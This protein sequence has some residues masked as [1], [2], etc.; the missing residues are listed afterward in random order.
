MCLKF[1]GG[2]QLRCKEFERMKEA[3][4]PTWK[5]KEK[6]KKKYKGSADKRWEK[7][8]VGTTSSFFQLSASFKRQ[9]LSSVLCTDRRQA[10]SG[11]SWP[12]RQCSG[13]TACQGWG[14]GVCVGAYFC[15][16][17]GCAMHPASPNKR[18]RNPN[19]NAS[20]CVCQLWYC[21]LRSERRRPGS[22]LHPHKPTRGVCGALLSTDKTQHLFC[23]W[24]FHRKGSG[25]LNWVHKTFRA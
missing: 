22:P 8:A 23:V 13:A 18:R 5:R 11:L 9:P 20:V 7:Q 15:F 3:L 21:L 16:R 19:L 25:C 1:S 4:S 24:F 12:F 2:Q 6:R 14:R 17:E 10:T